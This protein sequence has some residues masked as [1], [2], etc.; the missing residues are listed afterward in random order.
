MD[1]IYLD[2]NATTQIYP[3]VVEAMLPYLGTVYGNPSSIHS[4]GLEAK[5]A[6]EEARKKI[7]E[8]LNAKDTKNI[9]FTSC[10]SESNNLAIKGVALA[11]KKYG[12][13]I[14]T[15]KIEHHAVLEPCNYLAE[16]FGY[17]ITYLP[18]DKD[19]SVD[20]DDVRK[21]ITNKTIL[22]TIMHANNET[23]TIQ[24]IE[25]ISK[26]SAEYDIPFHTDAV[27]TAG[28]LPL[29][30]EKLGVDMLSISGHKLGAP[31]GIGALYMKMGKTVIKC[32]AQKRD[33]LSDLFLE[34]GAE[35][36]QLIHGGLH[37][38]NRRA[39]TENV[40]YIVGFAKACEI[41]AKNLEI[42][43]ARLSGLRDK[44]QRGIIESIKSARINGSTKKRLSNTL[45]VSF[46]GIE[47]ES[48]VY[49][50]DKE[51]IAVSTG[52]ACTTGATEPSHVLSAMGVHPIIAQGSIRFSLGHMN[53]EKDIDRVL[54]VLPCIIKNLR[55]MSPIWVEGVGLVPIE[56]PSDTE[57][58]G[59]FG[60]L[61]KLLPI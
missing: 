39:G 5:S 2:N 57:K 30:V 28:K 45:N 43:N 44:L 16:K 9:V 58:T 14:I 12:D 25:E 59:F 54:K 23:G 3:E 40:P 26:I 38:R 4:F 1:R 31:K 42:E 56:N 48:I 34:K 52:S 6:I 10:G 27:Q 36:Q 20:P 53:S 15:S 60:S 13:H 7:V 61:K 32:C 51:G 17:K 21:A 46:E 24:P 33:V 11:N 29:D 37:E 47:G 41:A 18:V 22:I 8:F 55:D 50:L 35:I 19:G 49:R